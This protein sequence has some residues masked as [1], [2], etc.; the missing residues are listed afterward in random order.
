[1]QYDLTKRSG[2]YIVLAMLI[3]GF[4]DNFF[5][6]ISQDGG[7]WQFHVTRTLMAL[8]ILFVAARV[9][10]RSLRP[11]NLSRV[12]ARSLVLSAGLMIYFGGLGRL[13]IA[14]VGAG[15]FTSPIWMLLFSMLFFKVRVGLWRVAA[16][17][18]GFGGVLVILRPDAGALSLLSLAPLLAGALYALGMMAT[19][20]WCGPENVLVL[21][22][23]LF[24]ALG[25]WG[26]IGLGVFSIWPPEGADSTNFVL[27]GWVQPTPRFL[28]WS[29]VQAVG[30]LVGVTLLS[31]AYQLGEPSYIAV[32]EYSFLLFAAFWAF[33]L[34][35]QR[36]DL[37]GALGIAA[38]IVS[39][40]IIALRARQP[41]AQAVP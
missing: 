36:V 38:I 13:P 9:S 2:V 7:L 39:G 15:L 11:K 3:L 29:L 33:V 18:L 20:Y 24:V 8:P 16:M 1:M 34:W 41:V 10:G 25:M 17:A 31:R 21:T 40:S 14:Q 37:A 22:V 5:G 23:G 4:I 35:G 6:E 19:R 28:F 12:V 27:R 30:S 26:V 32:F